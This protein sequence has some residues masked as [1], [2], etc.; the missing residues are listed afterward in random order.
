MQDANNIWSFEKPQSPSA[1]VMPSANPDPSS[2]FQH[3]SSVIQYSDM[4]A[5]VRRYIQTAKPALVILTPCY[6]SSMYAGY[7]ES[8]LKTMFLCKDL[9][10]PATIHFCRNDSLVSRARNNLIAK[11]MSIPNSTHFLFIDADITWDPYD[12]IKLLMADK[13]IVGGIY[14]IKNYQWEKIVENPNMIRDLMERKKKSQLD[15]LLTNDEYLKMNMVRYNINH[16]S[17]MLAIQ[18]NLTKVKHLA[19]GFMMIKRSV[20]ETM[21]RAFPQTKYVDDVCFLSGKENDYAYA[22]FDCG[23]EEGHYFSEDWLFCHRWS[24]MG[25]SIF[26]DVSINLD[27]TG[28]ETYRGSFISSIM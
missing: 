12:I 24:K 22:L 4:E 28:I 27:H 8:L 25:G 15:K 6:N 21:A 9:N 23:V 18:N 10:I 13:P 2:D 16:S 17:N 26:A 20:I 11:A 5:E 19:T 7:T 14:P 1:N 3:T